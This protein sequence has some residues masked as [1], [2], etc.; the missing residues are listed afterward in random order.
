MFHYPH[1]RPIEHSSL[2]LTQL[3][4][5]QSD[6]SRWTRNPVYAYAYRGFESLTLRQR[7]STSNIVELF[8]C[9]Q[10]RDF[11]RYPLISLYSLGV[12]GSLAFQRHMMSVA[13]FDALLSSSDKI[14]CFK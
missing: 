9:V 10:V 13:V 7:S 5:W 11:P 12:P 8:F 2:A 14:T 3:E 4:S 1:V 6:R